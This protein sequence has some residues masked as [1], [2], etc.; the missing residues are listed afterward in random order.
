MHYLSRQ[1]RGFGNLNAAI[2]FHFEKPDNILDNTGRV[3]WQ[4]IEGEKK[5]RTIKK[6][7]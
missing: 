1:G 6:K 2:F 5:M 3:A 7:S 4:N